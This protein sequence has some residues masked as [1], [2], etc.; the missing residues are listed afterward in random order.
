MKKEMINRKFLT[1]ATFNN[2]WTA[3][4]V[5]AKLSEEGIVAYLIDNHVN[6]SFGP[7]IL[8]G[9]RLQVDQNDFIKALNIYK[10]TLEDS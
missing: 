4:I 6:Y 3:E 5:K 1:L 9:Y 2:P 7:T 8:E 10:N